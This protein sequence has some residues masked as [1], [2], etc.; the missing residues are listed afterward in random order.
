MVCPLFDRFCELLGTLD[1]NFKGIPNTNRK[2]TMKLSREMMYAGMAW[3]RK[4]V[5]ILESWKGQSITLMMERT[6]PT[7]V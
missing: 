4:E 1:E 2:E 7:H 5:T 6:K 3:Y